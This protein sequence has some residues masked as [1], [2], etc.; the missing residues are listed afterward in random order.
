MKRVIHLM[1]SALLGISGLVCAS[2]CGRPHDLAFRAQADSGDV[3][4]VSGSQLWI[5]QEE[6]QPPTQIFVN[7]HPGSQDGR[8]R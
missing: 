1:A 8:T 4:K 7:G 2:D 6:Y 5:E 3:V